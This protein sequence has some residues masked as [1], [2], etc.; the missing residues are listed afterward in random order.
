MLDQHHLPTPH[1]LGPDPEPPGDRMAFLARP[2]APST[3][4]LA[5]RDARKRVIVVG[6]GPA[7]IEAVLALHELG[8][9]T[10]DIHLIAPDGDFRMRPLSVAEPFASTHSPSYPL[11]AL[12]PLGVTHHRDA[13]LAVDGPARTLRTTAGE[14]LAYDGLIIATG[15][16]NHHVLANALMFGGPASVADMHGLVQDLEGGWC[17]RVAFVAPPRASWTLPLYE[18]ALQTAARAYDMCMKEVSITVVTHEARPLEVFG[19]DGSELA[20]RLLAEAGIEVHTRARPSMPTTGHLLIQPDGPELEVD[21]VVA[22]PVPEGRPIPG[23]P[24]D[25]H[26][27]IKVD[28]F[29]RVLGLPRAYAA[30]DACNAS[31]IKQGGLATQQADRA[32]ETLLADLGLW[33]RPEPAPPH[34]RAVLTTGAT[35]RYLHRDATGTTTSRE[36]LWWPPSKI[37]GLRLAPFLDALTHGAAFEARPAPGRNPTRFGRRGEPKATRPAAATRA[38]S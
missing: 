27:F 16:R 30:G 12:A 5:A 31:A 26:G 20:E 11:G 18:L 15:A 9:T 17:R 13:L 32:A 14:S 25:A 29:G 34:L 36:P 35:T 23:L 6:A 38:Q 3:A 8:S 28:P 37:A 24:A 33:D 4:H 19:Y 2:G 7:A 1:D 22:L 21:R 10:V